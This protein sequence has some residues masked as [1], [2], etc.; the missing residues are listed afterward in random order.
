MAGIAS[1]VVGN[2][3]TSNDAKGA[4]PMINMVTGLD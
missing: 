4:T 3:A 2:D 1:E